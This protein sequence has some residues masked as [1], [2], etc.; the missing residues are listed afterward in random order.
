MVYLPLWKMSSSLGMIIHN[1][2]ES[3]NPFMF[4]TTNQIWN[5]AILGWFPLQYYPLI[6]WGRSE[7][8]KKKN[9]RGMEFFH[10]K[11]IYKWETC[12]RHLSV[13]EGTPYLN[14]P[15]NR[16]MKYITVSIL[17]LGSSC[18]WVSTI[19]LASLTAVWVKP[20]ICKFKYLNHPNW[21]LKIGYP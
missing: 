2:M 1:W 19:S 11:V 3:H 6:Q 8:V 14:W 13:P 18:S 7:I 12:H 20:R 15:I 17:L 5:K 9:T 10:G 21:C 4:Q 16:G